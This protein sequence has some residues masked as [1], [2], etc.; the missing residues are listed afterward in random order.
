MKE[1]NSVQTIAL[2]AS[3]TRG[4]LNPNLRENGKETIKYHI[5][6][7]AQLGVEMSLQRLAMRPRIAVEGALQITARMM[8]KMLEMGDRSVVGGL[9]RADPAV[10]YRATLDA[11]WM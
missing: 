5:R 9:M 4:L 2:I 7:L 11:V 10:A 3:S 1:K 6:R 8:F